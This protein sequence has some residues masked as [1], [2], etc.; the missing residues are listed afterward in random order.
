ML[1][2]MAGPVSFW[3]LVCAVEYLVTGIWIADAAVKRRRERNAS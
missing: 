2:V 3:L 1:Y